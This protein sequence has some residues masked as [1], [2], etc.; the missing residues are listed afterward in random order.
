MPKFDTSVQELKY[1]VLKEVARLAREDR[2]QENLLS[3]PETI[4]PGPE[5]TTRC[6]IY[7]ERAIVGQRIQMALGGHPEKKN[8][9][10]VL[11]IACDECPVSRMT[12]GDACRGC[13]ARRCEHVCPR[14][15]IS[16]PNHTAVIDPKK[17]IACGKCASACPYGAITK[18]VRPCERACK[19][20]AIHMDE[21]HKAEIDEE[22]CVSCGACVYQCPFG[23][24]VDKSYILSVVRL[25]KEAARE[26]AGPLYA[27]IAP[28]IAGQFGGVKTGQIVNA[29]KAL[30]FSDVIEAALGADIVAYREAKELKEKGF[31]TSSCCPAFVS[32]IR[33]FYPKMAE[34]ISSNLSP[35]AAIG[36]L[37]KKAHPNASIVFIGP[38][39]A[40][41]G[42]I[43]QERVRDIIDAAMTFEELQALFDAYEID[44]A[45]MEEGVLDNA[46][47]FGRIFARSGGLRDAV[48]EALKEQK[49]TDEEFH[50]NPVVCSGLEECKTALLKAQLGKLPE[51]F[52]EGM[53]CEQGCIGGPGCLTHGAKEASNV[54][55]YGRLALEKSIEDSLYICELLGMPAE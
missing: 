33:K 24:I 6:C 44:P 3:I 29:L 20:G 19:P 51:N 2:L 28:S 31:L 46:S 38:C 22:K 12:V 5:P 17:C 32:Y 15:A 37:I 13:I 39:V 27:V 42:E 16:H 52:I 25:L 48:A 49:V 4:I 30:G 45:A 11:T 26:G 55:K 9:V 50:L 36:Q 8:E 54:D 18:N 35:M 53:A 34:H 14:D 7:K 1:K 41:K 23:A 47:Y 21:N 40:K 43:K 10:E